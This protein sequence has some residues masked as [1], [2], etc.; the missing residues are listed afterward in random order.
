MNVYLIGFEAYG[1]KRLTSFDTAILV[2]KMSNI[3]K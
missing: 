2:E 3:L 1:M